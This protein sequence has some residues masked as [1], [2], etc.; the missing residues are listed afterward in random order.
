MAAASSCRAVA[1]RS[2]CC[3]GC[4]PCA[5]AVGAQAFDYGTDVNTTEQLAGRRSNAWKAL[6]YA[7]HCRHNRHDLS[8]AASPLCPLTWSL[9]AGAAIRQCII[10]QVPAVKPRSH[11]SSCRPSCRCCPGLLLLLLLPGSTRRCTAPGLLLPAAQLLSTYSCRD[12]RHLT[13]WPAAAVCSLRSA[14]QIHS[15]T[16]RYTRRNW[17]EQQTC[18]DKLCAAFGAFCCECVEPCCC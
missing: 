17:F 15:N 16:L 5:H 7:L 13:S 3:T 11:G 9:R 10:I 14:C 2:C 6:L 4:W 8:C 12:T 18:T 1:G